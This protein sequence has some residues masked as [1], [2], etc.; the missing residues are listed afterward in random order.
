MQTCLFF[1][2][3]SVKYSTN[4]NLG[5]YYDVT[6]F[7]PIQSTTLILFLTDGDITWQF[8]RHFKIIENNMVKSIFHNKITEKTLICSKFCVQFTLSSQKLC[9]KRNCAIE[10][11]RQMTDVYFA[12]S[13]FTYS[14]MLFLN[15]SRTWFLF[16]SGLHVC[17][18][19]N[20]DTLPSTLCRR[21]W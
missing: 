10:L 4:T 16:M 15:I 17:F 5:N 1:T 2:K 8:T 3:N 20:P 19:K 12:F 9:V 18:F 11:L 14:C 6:L 7:S 13:R 21:F